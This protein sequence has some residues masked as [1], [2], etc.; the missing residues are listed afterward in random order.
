MISPLP[1]WAGRGSGRLAYGLSFGLLRREFARFALQGPADR[2]E[3]EGEAGQRIHEVVRHELVK[4]ELPAPRT[5][6]E[7]GILQDRQVPR[8]G[9]RAHLEALR[10]LRGRKLRRRE[11]GQDFP[12][13]AGG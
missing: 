13:R 5:A 7:P 2:A 9:W 3:L 10:Q 12:P 11:I 6:D 8:D 4:D 1:Q